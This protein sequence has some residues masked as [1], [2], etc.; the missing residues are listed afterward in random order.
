[1]SAGQLGETRRCDEVHNNLE[2]HQKDGSAIFGVYSWS[3]VNITACE[4]EK[5]Q[6]LSKC[7]GKLLLYKQNTQLQSN[8]V[9]ITRDITLGQN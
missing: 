8:P 1:M 4:N 3:S 6:R 5:Q 9:N 7:K 2:S